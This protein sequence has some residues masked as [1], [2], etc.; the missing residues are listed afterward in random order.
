MFYSIDLGSSQK[1]IEGDVSG[2][3]GNIYFSS[4]ALKVNLDDNNAHTST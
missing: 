2:A 1:M 3:E 4:L